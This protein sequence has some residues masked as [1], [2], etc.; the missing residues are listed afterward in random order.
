MPFILAVGGESLS[1]SYAYF[2]CAAFHL[3][4]PVL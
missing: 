3:E 4:W 1:L 2:M